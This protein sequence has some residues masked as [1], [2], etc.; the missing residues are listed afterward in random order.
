MPAC[1]EGALQ[2]V[3]RCVF[4]DIVNVLKDAML[5]LNPDPPMFLRVFLVPRGVR[6]WSACRASAG[7]AAPGARAAAGVRRRERRIRD[8]GHVL[9]GAIRTFSVS[10]AP[11]RTPTMP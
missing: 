10:T 5:S 6:P 4:G 7:R 3:E 11:F 2:D 8:S 1:P 9:K